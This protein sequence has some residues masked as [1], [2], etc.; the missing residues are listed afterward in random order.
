MYK[1]IPRFLFAAL[2][3]TMSVAV[4]SAQDPR[5]AVQ[6][7]LARLAPNKQL[8]A[9]VILTGKLTDP[10]G[11]VQPFRITIKGKDKVRYEIGA[12][13]SLETTILSKG[14]GSRQAG[15]K[16]ELLQPYSAIQRPA[17]VPFLDL[18]AEADTPTLQVTDRGAASLGPV[19]TRR[20]TL[21]LPDPAPRQRMYGRPLDEEVD[22]YIDPVSGLVVRSE[23]WLMAENSMDVRFRAITDFAD[24]RSVQG[25]AIAFRI[26]TTVNVP[27][28]KQPFQ[29]VYAV[30]N[31]ILNSGVPESTFSPEVTTR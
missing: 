24:Y 8:P 13:S 20:Y 29:T 31:A 25:A 22:F 5:T 14:A 12:G 6:A 28:R 1:T 18:L 9:D 26:V 23:R 4:V 3:L 15:G 17:L 7:V 27:S 2:V 21:K 10:S 19:S 30:E 11:A 16:L